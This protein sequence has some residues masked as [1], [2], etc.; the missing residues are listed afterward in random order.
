MADKPRKRLEIRLHADQQLWC[1]TVSDSG[2]GIA[3][4]HL[5]SVFDPFFTTKP[6]GDGL[7]LGLAVSYAIV[8]ELGGRLSAGNHGDGAIF[9]LTLPIALETPDLC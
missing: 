9:T 2:G 8:H 6:V 7:G 1:L 3:E 4:E 5:N